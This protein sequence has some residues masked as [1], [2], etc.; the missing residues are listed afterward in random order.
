M[1]LAFSEILNYLKF[2]QQVQMQGL[3]KKC[4]DLVIPRFLQYESMA[5]RPTFVYFN[6]QEIK[7][8]KWQI[9]RNANSS[10]SKSSGDELGTFLFGD[11]WLYHHDAKPNPW[12]C[13][14]IKISPVM[15]TKGFKTVITNV[16][17]RAFLMGG[18]NSP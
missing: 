2:E 5:I 7:W 18:T 14:K 6:F 11:I 15:V 13:R 12:T 17:F 3:C 9:Q 16:R 8:Q 10:E 1:S 4:Y